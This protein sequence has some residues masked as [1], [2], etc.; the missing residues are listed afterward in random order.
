VP[1]FCVQ[2]ALQIVALYAFDFTDETSVCRAY[3]CL[4]FLF[5]SL[6][7]SRNGSGF[8]ATVF[9]FKLLGLMRCGR[10]AIAPE[11]EEFNKVS[12]ASYQPQISFV[13]I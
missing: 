2:T 9:H 3:S 12:L 7:G 4:S 6:L 10:N 13:L 1:E 11:D 5:N 8:I